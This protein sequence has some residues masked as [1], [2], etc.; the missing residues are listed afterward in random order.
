MLI[1]PSIPCIQS[2]LPLYH[3]WDQKQ[4][5][6]KHSTEPAGI[7]YFSNPLRGLTALTVF[8]VLW[9][10]STSSGSPSS[11]PHWLQPTAEQI[12]FNYR[13][14]ESEVKADNW[15]YMIKSFHSAT[16]TAHQSFILLKKLLGKKRFWVTLPL[17]APRPYVVR[18]L[19]PTS[20]VS[21]PMRYEESSRDSTLNG[22]A[23][24]LS[25]SLFHWNRAPSREGMNI[26]FPKIW[27][28]E[29]GH[30]NLIA[31]GKSKWHMIFILGNISRFR[32]S[33]AGLIQWADHYG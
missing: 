6:M 20:T 19:P 2:N 17:Y 10:N 12:Y 9:S 23:S 30:E 15:Y 1:Q 13:E 21:S 3:L 28:T 26:L 29:R 7:S 32:S 5:H 27:R 18:D 16:T 14:K 24:I 33:A 31:F 22:T 11:S 25:L 4:G 8:C